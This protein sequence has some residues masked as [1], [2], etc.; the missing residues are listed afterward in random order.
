MMTADDLWELVLAARRD[1]E[2]AIAA[3][4]V[5]SADATLSE[6]GEIRD[7][8]A[9]ATLNVMRLEHKWRRHI[10]GDDSRRGGL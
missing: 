7:R 2:Q 4:K 10:G 5:T 1:L 6:N 3:Q 8:V 9:A